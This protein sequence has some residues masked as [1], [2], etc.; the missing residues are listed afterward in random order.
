ME[1][2]LSTPRGPERYQFNESCGDENLSVG[3]GALRV[4]ICVEI[5]LHK[6]PLSK[7]KPWRKSFSNLQGI[8]VAS[9]SLSRGSSLPRSNHFLN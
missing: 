6:S 5:H 9:E 1:I 4:H 3:T 8:S 7:L 2:G